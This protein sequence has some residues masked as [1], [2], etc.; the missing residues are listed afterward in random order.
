MFKVEETGLWPVA[1]GTALLAIILL[2]LY[3]A[4]LPKPLLGIPYNEEAAGKIW[5]DAAEMTSA[6]RPRGWMRD[7][8]ER[9]NSPIVQ[10]FMS[11]VQKPWILVSDFSHANDIMMRRN[12]D[13]DR[14]GLTRD[15]FEGILPEFHFNMRS[16]DPRYKSNKEL[17]RDLMTPRFLNEVS[18]LSEACNTNAPILMMIL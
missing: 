17:L 7:Q 15:C 3:Q 13:F 2:L 4:A 5:G 10:L 11:P 8:F 16:K 9:H 6:K 1:G 18:T 12:K 14:S